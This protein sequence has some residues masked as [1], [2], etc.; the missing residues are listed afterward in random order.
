MR[1]LANLLPIPKDSPLTEYSQLRP[2]SLTN[3]IVRFFERTICVNELSHVMEDE[4]HKDQ[5]GCRKN[6]TSTTALTK[7]QH[8]WLEWLD[9]GK[10]GKS[11]LV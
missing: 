8:T 11:V 5:F 2:I 6:H 4:I 1:K 10:N 3:I 9:K 7:V